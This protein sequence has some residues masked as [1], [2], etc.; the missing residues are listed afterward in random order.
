MAI[1]SSGVL[2]T[3]QP[4]FTD[5]TLVMLFPMRARAAPAPGYRYHI[6]MYSSVG[7]TRCTV[8]GLQVPLCSCSRKP[9]HNRRRARPFPRT[10]VSPYLPFTLQ[11][12]QP[13]RATHAH[14]QGRIKNG[15]SSMEEKGKTKTRK[16]NYKARSTLRRSLQDASR[17]CGGPCMASSGVPRL[18]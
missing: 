6:H 4:K 5:V 14:R 16:G 11:P 7:Y 9:C 10:H 1:L 3:I 12:L 8:H 17:Q 13:L 18:V 15:R 2:C